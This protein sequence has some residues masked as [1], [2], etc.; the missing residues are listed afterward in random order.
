MK[1]LIE[2]QSE[3]KAPKSQRNTFGNYNYRSLEDIQEALKPLLKKNKCFVTVSDEI[4]IVGDRIYIKAT[5]TIQN[6]GGTKI[7]NTAYAREPLIKKGMDESQITGAT[8]SYARKYALNGLFAIDDTK[9]D[10]CTNAHEKEVKVDS[11]TINAIKILIYETSTDT[12]AFLNYFGVKSTEE[13]SQNAAEKAIAIL[14]KKPK[15][16]TTEVKV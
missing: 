1:E 5:A 6:E 4:V 3:L 14:D 2:I 8:S 9:D 10:D 16:P 11:K 13:L 7:Q 15:T 12:A